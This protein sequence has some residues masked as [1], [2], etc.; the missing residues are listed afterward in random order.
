MARVCPRCRQFRG[1]GFHRCPSS[2]AAP[3]APQGRIAPL[4][5]APPRETPGGSS[6]AA[7]A[8]YGAAWATYEAARR[9]PAATPGAAAAPPV[10][11]AAR[12][13]LRYGPRHR[14][15]G[16]VATAIER[17]QVSLS[18]PVDTPDG[19]R[20]FDEHAASAAIMD[21]ANRVHRHTPGPGEIQ[22]YSP[23]TRTWATRVVNF[24]RFDGR[25]RVVSDVVLRDDQGVARWVRPEVASLLTSTRADLRANT[26]LRQA[27]AV[28][29]QRRVARAVLADGLR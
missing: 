18:T 7:G 21:V 12:D 25:G 17:A 1:R 6:G 19:V 5:S 28:E 29:S 8:S 20:P 15:H 11:A 14:Y 22:V 24:T 13:G 3:Q 23:E 2:Q 26:E 16:E 4:S 27:A 9:T 10:P